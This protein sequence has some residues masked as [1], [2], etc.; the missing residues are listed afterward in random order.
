MIGSLCAKVSVTAA[1]A[2]VCVDS[3]GLGPGDTITRPIAVVAIIIILTNCAV[4]Y[5]HLWNESFQGSGFSYVM[6]N[7]IVLPGVC[8]VVLVHA[9][10]CFLFLLPETAQDLASAQNPPGPIFRV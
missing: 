9:A 8:L 4:A 10:E 2:V 7:I 6:I 1:H 3:P 5:V